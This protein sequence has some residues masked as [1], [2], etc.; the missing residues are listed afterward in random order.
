MGVVADIASGQHNKSFC[1]AFFKKRLL[2]CIRRAPL[3]RLPK[4]CHIPAMR[5]HASCA[6]RLGPDGYDAVLLT[7]PSGAGKSDLLLRLLDRGFRLVADDQ[8]I[9][10]NQLARA[11]SALAGLLEVRGLGIFR[12]PF[13]EAATPRLVVRLGLATARLPMPARDPGLGL[14]LVIIDP[15]HPSAP[16]RV[17]L[18]LEAAC[19]RITQPAG[20][21]AA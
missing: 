2:S 8:V 20:A 10:E 19:G 11:P 16:E 21:F 3:S 14:P 6:A 7:G 12:L 17:A 15:H 13:L 4:T 5:L 1:A 9:V 18:A